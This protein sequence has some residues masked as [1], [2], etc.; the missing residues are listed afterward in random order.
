MVNLSPEKKSNNRIRSKQTDQ[1]QA[2]SGQTQQ[3]I[4]A[5]VLKGALFK[6]LNAHVKHY[7]Y[8]SNRQL[9]DTSH[10]PVF[11]YPAIWY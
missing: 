8:N 7:K 3:G 4:V 6:E 11:N 5:P 10:S 9:V 1:S 2:G